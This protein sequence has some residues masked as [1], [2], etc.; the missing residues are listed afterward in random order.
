MDEELQFTLSRIDELMYGVDFDPVRGEGGIVVNLSVVRRDDLDDVLDVFRRVIDAELSVSPLVTLIEGRELGF[1]VDEVCIG[2]VCSI[3]IDSVLL[4]SGVPVSPRFGGVVEVVEGEPIRFT[5][6]LLY[7]G[8][9]IDPLEVLMSQELTSINDML[10]TGSG[11]ILANLRE[12]PMVARDV[13]E[14]CLSMLASSGFSGILEVGEPNCDVLSVGVG[15]DHMG[16]VVLGGT[17]PVAAAVE[18]GFRLKTHAMSLL[19]RCEDMVH[20]D[21]L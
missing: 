12:V 11:K 16:I 20:I 18:Q 1:G 8:T 19:V 3:T 4:K 6:M 10:N 5:D 7:E 13:V 17:N 21:E 2:N 15:R 9:T 14:E